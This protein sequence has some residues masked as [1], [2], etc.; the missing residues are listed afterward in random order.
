MGHVDNSMASDYRE[1]VFD[2]RLE[3]VANHVHAWLFKSKKGGPAK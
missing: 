1:D 2:H 3:A